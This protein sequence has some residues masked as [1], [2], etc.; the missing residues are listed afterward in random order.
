M[1]EEKLER[2]HKINKRI[3]EADNLTQVIHTADQEELYDK[4]VDVVDFCEHPVRDEFAYATAI[5]TLTQWFVGIDDYIHSIIITATNDKG[6]KYR[7][8]IKPEAR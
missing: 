7:I 2:S 8:T 3:I 1:S 4:I 6:E 5:L